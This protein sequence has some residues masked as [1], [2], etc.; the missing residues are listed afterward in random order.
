MDA[1]AVV[2]LSSAM[3]A[4]LVTKAEVRLG[5]T[6]SLKAKTN[7]AQ[8]STASV[9]SGLDVEITNKINSFRG[10]AIWTDNRAKRYSIKVDT[11][12]MTVEQPT[13]QHY[14]SRGLIR[15]TLVG[16]DGYDVATHDHV[17][18]QASAFQGTEMKKV[19]IDQLKINEIIANLLD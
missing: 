1:K 15:F 5:E 4:D 11:S 18:R 13:G 17:I 16:P 19:I 6:A 14:V 12:G 9:L 8:K 2:D 10:N 3:M 7:P